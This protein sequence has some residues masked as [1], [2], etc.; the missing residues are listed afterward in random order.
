VQ[1]SP[2]IL[3]AIGSDW[4]PGAPEIPSDPH[5]FQRRFGDLAPGQTIHAG[6]RVVTL[7]D[8][9]H[10]AHFTGDV[11]YA[12][13]DEAAAKANPFF[14]GRVAHGYLLLS[15]AAGLFV[16]PD[17]GPTLANTGLEGL[18]FMA[19]VS[20]GDAISVRLTV[21]SKK[22]RT[23]DYG[24]VRWDVAILKQAEGDEAPVQAAG[25]DLLTMN[26]V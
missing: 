26:A 21:K 10:F 23:P 25:Y 14:P 6:P 7:E 11:F 15:F 19:P 17:P 18:R 16:S 5:P 2:R 20:P 9:E 22:A 3:S 4:M 13:M 1:G 8:I 24:E 12:H